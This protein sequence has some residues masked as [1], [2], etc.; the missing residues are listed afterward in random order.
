MSAQVTFET[1]FFTPEPGEE[2]KTNPGRYGLA[3]AKWLKTQLESR[4]IATDEIISEDFGWVVIVSRKP[5]KLWL[6]CGNT[7]GSTVEWSVFPVA[8][9]S[10]VQR[11]LKRPDTSAAV[12]DLWQHVSV[13]VPTIPRVRSIQWEE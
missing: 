6:G 5:F 13:L 11:M 10:F 2:E 3:L 4:G 8:E 1:D 7:E 12:R 9:P